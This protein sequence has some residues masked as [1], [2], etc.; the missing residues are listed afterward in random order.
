MSGISPFPR[1]RGTQSRTLLNSFLHTTQS[2]ITCMMGR[3]TWSCLNNGSLMY[4]QKLLK[5][6]FRIGWASSRERKQG[7]PQ[8]KRLKHRNGS[9][10]RKGIHGFYQDQSV[11]LTVSLS[12]SLIIYFPN[13]IQF[14]WCWSENVKS[15]FQEEKNQARNQG[16]GA[17][18]NGAREWNPHQVGSPW[19]AW[20]ITSP[21]WAIGW[22]QQ[23][24]CCLSQ[25]SDKQRSRQ[26][27]D[28]T[29]ICS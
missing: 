8:V 21:S 6:S 22:G 11:T 15:W 4:V 9:R 23:E 17:V 7:A 16:R 13:F 18:E 19:S 28:R 20:A 5:T 3:I 26:A 12:L 2:A 1:M 14:A 27:R 29:L 24:C 10:D 25:W